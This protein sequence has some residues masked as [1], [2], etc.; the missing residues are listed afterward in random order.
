MK[1]INAF[2]CYTAVAV[3]AIVLAG[4]VKVAPYEVTAGAMAA[5][6]VVL[7]TKGGPK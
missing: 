7:T 5:T 6:V 4:L 1:F 3:A 2:L